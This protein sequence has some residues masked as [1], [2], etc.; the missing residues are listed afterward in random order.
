MPNCT[1]QTDSAWICPEHRPTDLAPTIGPGC[2]PAPGVIEQ[3]RGNFETCIACD[4]WL[5][6]SS[7]WSAKCAFGLLPAG[8]KGTD[9]GC[10]HWE[11]KGGKG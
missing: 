6:A 8:F 3:R 9:F 4:S 1:C 11:K 2:T 5:V 10:I 7:H